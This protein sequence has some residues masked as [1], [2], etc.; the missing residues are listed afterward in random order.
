MND[1]L[2]ETFKTPLKCMNCGSLNLLLFV[3]TRLKDCAAWACFDCQKFE[4]RVK[5]KNKEERFKV[6]DDFFKNRNKQLKHAG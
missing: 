3:E 4:V 5:G 6:L 1:D 2:L